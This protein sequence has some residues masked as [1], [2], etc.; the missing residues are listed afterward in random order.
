VLGAEAA[1]RVPLMERHS[2]R[3]E[4]P[5]LEHPEMARPGVPAG[6]H[7]DHLARHPAR[8]SAAA[9]RKVRARQATEEAAAVVVAQH[10]AQAERLVPRALQAAV[11]AVV[12]EAQQVLAA[13]PTA[14]PGE[15]AVQG[16]LVARQ[17][18]AESAG[19]ARLREAAAGQDVAAA[20]RRAAGQASAA[21]RPQGA[22]VAGPA[23]VAV[24]PRGAEVAGPDA[25]EA[26][27]RGV[28]AEVP[29]GVAALR[30][31][32]RAGPR[33]VLLWG[34]ALAGLPSIRRRGDRLAP[35][36]RARSAHARGRLRTA[37]SSAR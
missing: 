5:R 36:A 3:V 6:F 32:A 34:P 28:E 16:A 24:R 20:Q 2:V 37:Q 26:P 19:E 30:P 11:V 9:A 8:P 13:Q 15:V 27:R 29:D 1:R 14:V 22:E 21:V 23:S 33:G 12:R 7:R 10:Q 18:A 4:L 35:S 17:P 31:G 25:E